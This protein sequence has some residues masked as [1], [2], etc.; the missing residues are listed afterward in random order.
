MADVFLCERVEQGSEGSLVAI[1]RVHK[2]LLADPTMIGML[3]DEISLGRYC[4]HPNLVATLDSGRSRG[5]AY[6]VMEYVDGLNLVQIREVLLARGLHFT[7]AQAMHIAIEISKSLAY[8]HELSDAS[9]VRLGVVHRDVTPPNVL[10]GIDGSVKLCDFGFA[11]SRVQR[12]KTDAG[13]IKGKFSY[14]SPEAT[15]EKPVDQRADV[16][17]VG[18]VLWEMLTMHRLFHADT[19]YDTFKMVQRTEVP[20]LVSMGADADSVLEEIVAKC[21]AKDPSDRYQSAE[22]MYCALAAYEDW[23]ELSCDLGQFV[24][25]LKLA[26]PSVTT[27]QKANTGLL[28]AAR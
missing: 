20:T 17:A 22:A 27:T 9:G 6:I 8:L 5:Q 11:K 16:F 14:L 28:A 21:L 1:K 2:H 23:Q 10:L 19:D 24:R 7:R 13:I 18:I 12:I 3:L 26:Q 4:S 15:L 25:Q